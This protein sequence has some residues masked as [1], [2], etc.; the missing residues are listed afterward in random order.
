[1]CPRQ[2]VLLK[3]MD[4]KVQLRASPLALLD[5]SSSLYTFEQYQPEE[6]RNATVE[7]FTHH[8]SRQP[9]EGLPSPPRPCPSTRATKSLALAKQPRNL[10]EA[11]VEGWW[12]KTCWYMPSFHPPK[13]VG[14]VS[15]VGKHDF[16]SL[17]HACL[18]KVPPRY[19]SKE[20]W[21]TWEKE[22]TSFS[23]PQNKNQ[24]QKR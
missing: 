2:A 21:I 19:S 23:F 5:T 4:V 1:M 7:S 9:L 15:N 3:M 8:P 18:E 13:K 16:W 20:W 14:G 11:P 17:R 24:L 22:P 6:P 10:Q 12:M